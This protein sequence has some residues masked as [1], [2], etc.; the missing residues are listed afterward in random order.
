VPNPVVEIADDRRHYPRLPLTLPLR[1]KRVAGQPET[2][3]VALVTR[4]ISSSGV[5]FIA[6]RWI[7]PGTPVELEIS[8][9]EGPLGGRHVRMHT[10]GEVVRARP[11]RTQGWHSLAVAFEDITFEREVVH[12]ERANGNHARRNGSNGNGRRA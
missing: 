11:T 4:D 1:L 12:A 8:L 3:P 10:R 2:E 7:E 6:P 9:M 5:A